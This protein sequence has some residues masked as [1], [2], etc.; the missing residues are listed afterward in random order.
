VKASKAFFEIWITSLHP[1]SISEN[2]SSNLVG[3][4]G[5]HYEG[6][7]ALSGERC[8]A[9]T[10]IG[11]PRR[12]NADASKN[13]IGCRF[14]LRRASTSVKSAGPGRLRACTH[15][16]P[17]TRG[18]L[19]ISLGGCS[20]R[21]AGAGFE[22]ATRVNRTGACPWCVRLEVVNRGWLRRAARGHGAP[23]RARRHDV[24]E[25]TNAISARPRSAR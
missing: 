12:P 17:S 23:A 25:T 24:V 15:V 5:N 1:M 6:S 20:L 4:Y 2:S 16:R 8:S 13:D 7:R 19:G 22:G 3:S 9:T 18:H 14:F 10:R 21:R 11:A